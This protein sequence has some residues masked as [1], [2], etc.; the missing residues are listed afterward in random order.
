MLFISLYIYEIPTHHCP[1]CILK[2]EYHFIGYPLYAVLLGGAVSGIGA[3]VIQPYKTIGSLALIVPALQKRLALTAVLGYAA[4][5]LISL[6]YV[7]FTEFH[8]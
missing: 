1:F 3:G 2:K 5:T 7:I 8:L 4:F 6:Y